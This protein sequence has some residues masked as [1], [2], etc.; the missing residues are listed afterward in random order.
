M[1]SFRW[2]GYTR[3]EGLLPS[4]LPG[5]LCGFQEH[6]LDH[7]LIQGAGWTDPPPMVWPHLYRINAQDGIFH[8]GIH[9]QININTQVDAPW[10][11]CQILA[12]HSLPGLRWTTTVSQ[13]AKGHAPL[14]GTHFPF[15]CQKLCFFPTRTMKKAQTSW[16]HRTPC[17]SLWSMLW[18]Q[19]STG[20]RAWIDA[21]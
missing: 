9:R 6:L 13:K 2:W 3:Q 4:P 7:S 18:K 16:E 19:H 21:I 11:H 15:C 12:R 14:C 5:C 8:S 1:N 10:R 17:P 20:F